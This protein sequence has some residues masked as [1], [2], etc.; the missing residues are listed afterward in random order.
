[1]ESIMKFFHVNPTLMS[2][3]VQA[4]PEFCGDAV[5]IYEAE[6]L[7]QFSNAYLLKL[8]NTVTGQ[9]VKR[10]ADRKSAK[11]RTWTALN[12]ME[13]EG[14][15]P[16]PAPAPVTPT[17]SLFPSPDDPRVTNKGTNRGPAG[18]VYPEKPTPCR[19]GTKQS[20]IVNL[21]SRPQ[22]AT[23]EELMAVTNWNHATVL[24]GLG[25]DMRLHGYK[26]VRDDKDHYHL[27]VPEGCTIPAH[28]PLKKAQ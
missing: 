6:Q 17:T 5:V 1:M 7:D 16:A 22:G 11:N 13:F 12:T 15:E 26:T 19:Q 9:D 23:I 10:F 2:V 20:I 25:W 18:R 24:S 4:S 27:V 21:T 14:G 3:S 8:F 28:T